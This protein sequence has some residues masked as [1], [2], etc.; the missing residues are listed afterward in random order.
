MVVSY[1]HPYKKVMAPFNNPYQCDGEFD[2]ERFVKPQTEIPKF[3][4]DTINKHSI[5]GILQRSYEISDLYNGYLHMDKKNY[6]AEMKFI[7][8][9]PEQVKIELSD[10]GWEYHGLGVFTIEI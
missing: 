2:N 4:M 5:Q 1:S 3:V 9:L 10:M 8:E 7:Y 6:C